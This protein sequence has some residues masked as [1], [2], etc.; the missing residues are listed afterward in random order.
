MAE[1]NQPN[2]S[3]VGA[4]APTDADLVLAVR[5]GDAHA[6]FLLWS[7][8]AGTVQRLVGRFLGP[9]PD[10]QDV[11]QEVFL[12]IF[13]RIREVQ[14]PAALFGFVASVALGVARNE[15]RRRRIRAIVGLVPEEQLPPMTVAAAAGE[16]REAVRALYQMLDSLSAQD[17]SLFVARFVEKMELTQ[18]A[19]AHAMSLSTAKRRL[20][21]LAERVNA[22]VQASPALREYLDGS[23]RGGPF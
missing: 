18:V 19:A 1:S 6:C 22:H 12:R 23:G 10:H 7:R 8:Y 15:T 9:G 2:L 4:A 14:Q 17:R 3:A 16:V 13:K 21:R 20:A 5:A 11:C